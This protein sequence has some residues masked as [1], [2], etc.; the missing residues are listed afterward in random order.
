MGKDTVV[1]RFGSAI[2]SV[3]KGP[4]GVAEQVAPVADLTNT[5]LNAVGDMMGKDDPYKAPPTPEKTDEAAKK[6]REPRGRAATILTGGR[7]LEDVP[8]TSAKRVLLG[9]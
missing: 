9:R 6:E 2:G 1:G 7:G 5:M 8:Y 3:F 4:A